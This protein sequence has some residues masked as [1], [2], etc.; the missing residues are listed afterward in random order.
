MSLRYK[1]V[2]DILGLVDDQIRHT[3]KST[4]TS[5]SYLTNS[6]V[7]KSEEELIHIG[8]FVIIVLHADF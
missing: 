6:A 3:H 4:L 5:I 1:K 2:E 7:A 8:G